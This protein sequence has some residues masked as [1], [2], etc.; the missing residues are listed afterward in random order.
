[1]KESSSSGS[2]SSGK[3]GDV[4][5]KEGTRCVSRLDTWLDGNLKLSCEVG[6]ETIRGRCMMALSR[7]LACD[8]TSLERVLFVSIW[9]VSCSEGVR[10]VRLA[11]LRCAEVGQA[12]SCL[13]LLLR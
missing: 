1:M 6:E 13:A 9:L 2:C 7:V 12:C 3:M 5:T 10:T 4:E 8:P 11:N